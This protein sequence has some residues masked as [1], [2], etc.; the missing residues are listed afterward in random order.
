VTFEDVAVDFVFDP[1]LEATLEA[2]LDLA[3][4]PVGGFEL[5][6]SDLEGFAGPLSLSSPAASAAANFSS[7]SRT[8]RLRLRHSRILALFTTVWSVDGFFFD[9]LC[10]HRGMKRNYRVPR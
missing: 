10:G 6:F 7:C 8:V 4:D 3:V 5:A 9:K 1:D 2:D